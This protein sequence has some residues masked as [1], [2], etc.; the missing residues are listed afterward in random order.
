MNRILPMVL[1]LV[2]VATS[3]ATASGSGGEDVDVRVPQGQPVVVDGVMEPDEWADAL[4]IEICEVASLHLKHAD[5]YLCVGLSTQEPVVGNVLIQTGSQIRVM[6]SSAALGTAMYE[7]EQAVWRR[8]QGFVWRCRSRILTE[9]ALQQRQVFLEEEGWLASIT[10][11][12]EVNH[13]EYR[14]ADPAAIERLALVLLPASHPG[15]LFIWPVDMDQDIFPG[16]INTESHMAPEQWP[17]L[18]LEGSTPAT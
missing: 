11:M 2:A 6:H 7:R 5:G 10:Y 12:G 16:P 9:A 18:I 17:R 8:T 15:D 14:I 3:E 13:L 4:V 1:V